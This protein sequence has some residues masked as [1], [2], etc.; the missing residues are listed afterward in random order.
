MDFT[1][2]NHL[3]TWE[4]A[5]TARMEGVHILYICIYTHTHVSLC[6]RNLHHIW[7][8]QDPG[9]KLNVSDYSRQ[10]SSGILAAKIA[11]C[12]QHAPT[13]LHQKK[14]LCRW[15]PQ[16]KVYTQYWEISYGYLSL[17]PEALPIHNTAKLF[18]ERC[19]GLFILG[20]NTC[21]SQQLLFHTGS[22]LPFK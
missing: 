9:Q 21:G 16:A 8:A 19:I 13:T 3:A 14:S 22:F 2:L 6:Q 7:V 5:V 4:T 20:D 12:V 10:R 18:P 1:S 15:M 11:P 17:G